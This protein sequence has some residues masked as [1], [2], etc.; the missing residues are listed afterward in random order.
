MFGQPDIAT[1]ADNLYS[2]TGRR[3][4]M[5]RSLAAHLLWEQGVGG[6]NPPIPTS[7]SWSASKMLVTF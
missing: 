3:P 6:S 4:G 5:W 7:G 1:L 2:Y